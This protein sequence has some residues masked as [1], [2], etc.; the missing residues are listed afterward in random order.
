MTET[1]STVT[2]TMR[3]LLSLPLPALGIRGAQGH[4]P[5]TCTRGTFPIPHDTLGLRWG[6]PRILSPSVLS[7][8]LVLCCMLIKMFLRDPSMVLGSHLL[9]RWRPRGLRACPPSPG[10]PYKAIRVPR[11]AGR[12]LRQS[13]AGKASDML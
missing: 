8:G 6:G 12:G 7:S 1:A 10:S 4:P 9:D 11:H 13:K 3:L 5:C 2:R